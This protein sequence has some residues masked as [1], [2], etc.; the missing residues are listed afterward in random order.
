[1]KRILVVCETIFS[2]RLA[3]TLGLRDFHNLKVDVMH[4]SEINKLQ[5]LYL[6]E[7]QR[8]ILSRSKF[9]LVKFIRLIHRY[10]AP[11]GI[12]NQSLMDHLEIDSINWRSSKKKT[13]KLIIKIYE[14]FKFVRRFSIFTLT[15]IMPRISKDMQN[16]LCIYD[17]VFFFSLGNLKPFYVA[18]LHNFCKKKKIKT[19]CYIQSWDNPS[20]KGYALYNPD[21]ILTW[22]NL[23]Q[24]ELRDYMD[25]PIERTHSVGSPLFIEDKLDININQHILFATKRPKTFPHKAYI[26][27]I[28]AKE[29]KKLDVRFSVRIHPW[30]VSQKNIDESKDIINVSKK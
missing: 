7:T 18:P 8:N 22:T 27:E 10:V 4:S 26:S 13:V 30:S 17:G 5:N 11:F 9:K 29:A 20:T 25:F 6:K 3:S 21:I 14:R 15:I 23:M 16:K 28:I 19:F 2:D 24:H 12:P 1:M